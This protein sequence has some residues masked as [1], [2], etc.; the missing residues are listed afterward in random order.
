VDEDCA[1]SRGTDMRLTI[2]RGWLHG[3]RMQGKQTERT[4]LANRVSMVKFEQRR[5]TQRNCGSSNSQLLCAVCNV[6][7]DEPREQSRPDKR[8]KARAWLALL[9]TPWDERTSR[10][11][12][13]HSRIELRTAATDTLEHHKYPEILS[14]VFATVLLIGIR[15]YLRD[16]VSSPSYAASRLGKALSH[17]TS[18]F[19]LEDIDTTPCPSPLPYMKLNKF[20]P[21][22]SLFSSPLLA[23]TCIL[24]MAKSMVNFST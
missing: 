15:C 5:M 19:Y 1:S 17:V 8:N 24:Y 4:F 18:P 6:T 12:P 14:L 23:S 16:A 3:K 13:F 21:I 2:R 7:D 9:R 10:R 11:Y 20:G 22:C